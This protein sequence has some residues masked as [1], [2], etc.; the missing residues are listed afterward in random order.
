[1]SLRECPNYVKRTRVD[2]S[3]HVY[4]KKHKYTVSPEYVDL[5]AET[6]QKIRDMSALGI[7]STKIAKQVGVSVYRVRA[8]LKGTARIRGE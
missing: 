1:M 3:V 6:A 4:V 7:P 8:V 5:T 2:G